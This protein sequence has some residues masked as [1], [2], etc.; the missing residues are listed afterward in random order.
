MWGVPGDA[1]RQ[2]ARRQRGTAHSLR[3]SLQS[4]ERRVTRAVRCAALRWRRAPRVCRPHALASP[5]RAFSTPC[6]YS[7]CSLASISPP[8]SSLSPTHHT[9]HN[10]GTA[11]LKGNFDPKALEMLM[12]TMQVCV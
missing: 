10:Q 12:S 8:A 5:T 3:H 9:S 6:L 1:H 11:V 2:G 7:L 4:E